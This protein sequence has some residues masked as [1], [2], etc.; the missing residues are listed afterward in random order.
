[1]FNKCNKFASVMVNF[2][3]S[4]LKHRMPYGWLNIILYVQK[5]FP[6]ALAFE[7]VGWIKQMA[8]PSLGGYGWILRGSEWNKEQKEVGFQSSLPHDFNWTWIYLQ[9]SSSQVFRPRP[10]SI[11]S[12]PWLSGFELHYL[13]SW[14]SLQTTSPYLWRSWKALSKYWKCICSIHDEG[15]KLERA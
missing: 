4:W 10:E 9:H 15:W 11:P 3:S 5:T 14:V 1:M 12:G 6:N 7:L 8:L 13:P 2:M